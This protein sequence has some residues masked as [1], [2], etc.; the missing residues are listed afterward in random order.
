MNRHLQNFFTVFRSVE[1]EADAGWEKWSE[2]QKN[3]LKLSEEIPPPWIVFPNSSPIY[4]WNQGYQEAWKNNVWTIFWHKLV[5]AEKV[6][7]LNRW[8]PPSEEWRETITIYW[9]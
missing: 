9:K 6:D 5:G 8:K 4:G 3:K 7:Y 2:E 1:D